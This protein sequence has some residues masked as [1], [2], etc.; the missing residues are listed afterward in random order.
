MK[1][2][3]LRQ[4]V[5]ALLA[6]TATAQQS[7]RSRV[8]PITAPIRQLGVYH[9]ATGTWTRDA[10]LANV[11]GPELIYNNTCSGIY[12]GPTESGQEFQHR[13]RIP[14]P[15]GPTWPSVFYGAPRND[16]APGCLTSYTINGFQV[17]YCSGLI[18]GGLT[19]RHKFANSYTACGAADMVPNYTF[20]ITGLPGGTATGGEQCWIIDVDTSATSPAFV[21]SGDGDGTYDGT[22]APPNNS[23][24]DQ[25]GWGMVFT[26]PVFTTAAG[27][28]P[29][30]AGNYTW[31]GGPHVGVLTP[32]TGTDGTIWDAPIN[33]AEEG[34]GMSSNDFF[35][36]TPA[37]PPKVG[38]GCYY[39][40]GQP[41][42]D[43]HLQLYANTGCLPQSPFTKFCFPGSDGVMNCPCNNPPS[44]HG[45]GCNNF[46]AMTG[47]ATLDAVGTS[48]LSTDTV[49]FTATGENATS[50]TIFL[51]GTSPIAAGVAFGAGVRCVSG[52]LKR[53]YTGSASGGTISRPSSGQLRVHDRSAQLGDVIQAG[54]QRYYLAY[55]RDP[56]AAGPCG[57]ITITFNATQS[58]SL[59]WAP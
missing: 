26:A 55:Y 44:A 16:E 49:I 21:L 30:I 28:G 10:T 41:H 4:L 38:P 56:G 9:V 32:C 37:S 3:A 53:L 20:T 57:N 36:L 33:L 35:R 27:T 40:G 59:T 12:Y 51:Q 45:K 18:G 13:S 7:L 1:C 58:G 43:F 31:T 11:T 6:G 14:S 42:A 39:F 23:L 24:N 29:V 8:M 34:T 15:S 47:G 17:A 52:S 5:L 22:G 25:F 54:Q 2:S 19:W 50:F 46:A 48:G